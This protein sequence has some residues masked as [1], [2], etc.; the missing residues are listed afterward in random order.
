MASTG[1]LGRDAGSAGEFMAGDYIASYLKL[2]VSNP[3]AIPIKPVPESFRFTVNPPAH[4]ET[5]PIFKTS[6]S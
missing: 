3:E 5:A 6:T 4:L 2:S 1:Q